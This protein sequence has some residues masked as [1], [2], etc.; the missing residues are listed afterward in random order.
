MCDARVELPLGFFSTCL[1]PVQVTGPRWSSWGGE[2]EGFPSSRNA[3]GGEERVQKQ[4]LVWRGGGR[5]AGL[6][7]GESWVQSPSRRGSGHEA[8]RVLTRGSVR[9]TPVCTVSRTPAPTPDVPRPRHCGERRVSGPGGPRG[10]DVA[11]P[12]FP[13]CPSHPLLWVHGR[14]VPA[15]DFSRGPGGWAASTLPTR[16]LQHREPGC[17]PR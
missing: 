1:S 10:G 11:E 13:L 14:G 9:C 6:W 4:R 5:G 15:L 17:R 8:C 3:P 12:A 2:E 7:V 16:W